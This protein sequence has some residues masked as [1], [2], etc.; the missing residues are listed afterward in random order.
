VF[1]HVLI[2][3]RVATTDEAADQAHPQG[4]PVIPKFNT[5]RANVRS[6]PGDLDLIQVAARF[7]LK[8]PGQ[9]QFQDE[10]G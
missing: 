10:L 4:R 6:R 5:L 8:L 9:E 3:G 7:L 1:E 2:L